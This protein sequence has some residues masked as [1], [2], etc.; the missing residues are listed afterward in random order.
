MTTTAVLAV[1]SRSVS[2]PFST[3]FG[4][5][6]KAEFTTDD[7]QVIPIFADATDATF[8]SISKGSTV[9]LVQ[10]SKGWAVG[11]VGGQW[12]QP[13]PYTPGQQ[14]PGQQARP[15]TGG[16]PFMPLPPAPKH[17]QQVRRE[18]AEAAAERIR[19]H[20]STLGYCLREVQQCRTLNQLSEEGQRQMAITAFIQSQ[21]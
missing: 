9:E 17:P 5:R 13:M 12:S 19:R 11:R 1:C 20:V 8:T 18:E 16:A 10:G 14:A 6:V 7:G 2:K 15:A 4:D 21:R 3:R